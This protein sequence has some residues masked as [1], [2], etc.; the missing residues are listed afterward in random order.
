MKEPFFSVVIPTK[1]RSAIVGGAIRSVLRQTF[2][3]FELIVCDNDDGDATEK[4]T[5]QFNDLRLRHYR[6]GGLSMPDNWEAACGAAKG[7]FLVILEDKQAL[8]GRALERIHAELQKQDAECVRWLVDVLDDTASPTYVEQERCSGES[9]LMSSQECLRLFVH[10]TPG[11]AWRTAPIGHLSAISRALLDRIRSQP[12]FRVCPPAAPDYCLAILAL[13]HTKQVLAIDASLVAQTRKHSNG[14]SI[15]MKTAL[16]QQFAQ[17]LGGDRLLYHRVP[18][19]A[20]V[21]FN[22]IWND[23]VG[24]FEILGDKLSAY[25]MDIPNYFAHC[26]EGIAGSDAQGVDM[27]AEWLAWQTAFE[28]QP[29]GEKLRIEALLTERF[30][31]PAKR[32]RK[33]AYKKFKRRTG[34][35]ALEDGWR[36]L[37]RRISGRKLAGR[38]QSAIEYVEWMDRQESPELFS[39]Q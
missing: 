25:P 30:G 17:E 24:L 23:Y 5:R 38:F 9:R 22:V 31:P 16:G 35:L 2:S 28:K 8:R 18:I 7:R 34:L 33:A 32:Q 10:G 1:G 26:F 21:N 11:D 15:S 12:P 14:R 36:G 4:V 39:A 20:R 29:A 37:T 13:A 19:A 6:T 27:A 3:D